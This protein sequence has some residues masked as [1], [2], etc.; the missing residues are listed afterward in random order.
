M[1]NQTNLEKYYLELQ[2]ENPAFTS[3]FNKLSEFKLHRFETSEGFKKFLR[4]AIG[5]IIIGWAV[6]LIA[7]TAAVWAL[8][9]QIK[10]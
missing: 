10:I 5:T 8:Y 1:K 7:F 2:D 9:V 3:P 4:R 6:G